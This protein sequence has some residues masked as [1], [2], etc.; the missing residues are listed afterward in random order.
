MDGKAAT[1]V[2]AIE[3]T[4]MSAPKMRKGAGKRDR[5]IQN[6]GFEPLKLKK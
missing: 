2:S 1:A 5:N 3:G 4:G 6:T